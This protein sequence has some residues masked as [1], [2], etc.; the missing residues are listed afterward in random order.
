M[1][2][3]NQ[4]LA[5]HALGDFTV[6]RAKEV[7]REMFNKP[8]YPDAVFV[9]QDSMA[10]AVMDVLRNELN[11]KIPDDVSVIGYDDVPPA[12]LAAY[13]LTTMRQRSNIM[14]EE[15]VSLMLDKITNPS[16]EPRHIKVESPLI[17]RSSAKVPKGW[18]S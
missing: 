13:D 10:F 12:A 1:K 15:T 11:L 7:A 9:V 6:E 16:L 2:E 8:N 14:V 18:T 3:E 5:A 4:Q 17:I